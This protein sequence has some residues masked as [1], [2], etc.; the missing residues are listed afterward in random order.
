MEITEKET[1]KFQLS[2]YLEWVEQTFYQGRDFSQHLYSLGNF[3]DFV[4]VAYKLVNNTEES[5]FKELSS[6]F[7]RSQQYKHCFTIKDIFPNVSLIISRLPLS[8]MYYHILYNTKTKEAYFPH[9]NREHIFIEYGQYKPN[10]E[11]PLYLSSED[12]FKDVVDFVPLHKNPSDFAEC[13]YAI[14]KH[15]NFYLLGVNEI[16]NVAK[17]LKIETAEFLEAFPFEKLR[18]VALISQLDQLTSEFKQFC[19]EFERKICSYP[20][21]EKQNF[22][23]I[24]RSKDNNL[25]EFSSELQYKFQESFQDHYMHLDKGK[26]YKKRLSYFSGDVLKKFFEARRYRSVTTGLF[27]VMNT[28]SF[29]GQEVGQIFINKQKVLINHL[30][31]SLNSNDMLMETERENGNRYRMLTT[32]QFE[33]NKAI[34]ALPDDKMLA[35]FKKELD[36][37]VNFYHHLVEKKVIFSEM[38]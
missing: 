35:N 4:D 34:E 14:Y 31:Y 26:A 22:K 36:P 10:F 5:F 13:Y 20:F 19:E 21:I 16:E 11:T 18:D 24:F 12:K 17:E 2:R 29:N 7:A 6:K 8:K 15:I 28:A 32:L 1:R 38:I 25:K 27:Y 37:F 23:T 3:V 30:R 9:F 33:L